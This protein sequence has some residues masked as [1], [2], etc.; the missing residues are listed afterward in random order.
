MPILISRVLSSKAEV[1]FTVL[2]HIV[3]CLEVGD[4]DGLRK[5]G[6]SGT[7]ASSVS[8]LTLEDLLDLARSH[9]GV[10][11]IIDTVDV[12]IDPAGLA[13]LLAQVQADREGRWLKKELIL[14]DAPLP[15][16]FAFYSM[17]SREYTFL[18]KCYR[19]TGGMGRPSYRPEHEQAVWHA[20]KKLNKTRKALTPAD[21]LVLRRDAG[22][23]LR[24][25][26]RLFEDWEAEG[27]LP[28]RRSVTHK[29]HEPFITGRD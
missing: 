13:K 11:N 1:M 19:R 26:W 5:M 15:L 8:M 24:V 25:I 23:S 12:K 18:R 21:Y 6:L 9:G 20:F 27:L 14:N 22:V 4:V 3:V 7:D 2:R 16:M 10:N 29:N 17:S 28:G